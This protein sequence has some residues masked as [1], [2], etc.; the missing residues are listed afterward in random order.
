[1]N[2]SRQNSSKFNRKLPLAVAALLKSR[3]IDE[4]AQVIDISTSTLKRW[5]RKP[6]F[7]QA[8]AAAQAEVFSSVC[9]EVRQL[10]TDATK[11]LGEVVR[12]ST[13]PASAR[14][15]AAGLLISLLLRIHSFENQEHRLAAIERRL[16]AH[17]RKGKESFR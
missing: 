17:A 4:A 3:S 1:M 6:E 13:V 16:D 9:N 7:A 15:R 14:T 2:P 5:Q 8:L 10:G 12:S 11:A